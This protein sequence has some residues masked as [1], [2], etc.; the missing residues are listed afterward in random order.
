MLFNIDKCKVMYLGFNNP[1]TNY[2]VEATQ[3]QGVSEDTDLG[4]IVTA[5]LKWK[6]NAF[7]PLR[8]GNKISVV[9]VSETDTET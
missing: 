2:V 5:D 6:N 1:Q 9:T 3:L 8:K 4:I 7:L